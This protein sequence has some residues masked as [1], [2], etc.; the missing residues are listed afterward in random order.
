MAAVS[1]EN[2][3]YFVSIKLYIVASTR[4]ASSYISDTHKALFFDKTLRMCNENQILADL[5]RYF[6][7]LYLNRQYRRDSVTTKPAIAAMHGPHSQVRLG[8]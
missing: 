3:V 7:A 1:K 8:N 6:S 5:Y 4:I 2:L